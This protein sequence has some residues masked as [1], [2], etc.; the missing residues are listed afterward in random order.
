[1]L[2]IATPSI[3]WG[4]IS[5]VTSNLV[6]G[7]SSTSASGKSEYGEISTP[8]RQVSENSVRSPSAPKNASLSRTEALRVVELNPHQ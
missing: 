3:R 8:E 4:G 1:M 2:I 7:M 6:P 5:W